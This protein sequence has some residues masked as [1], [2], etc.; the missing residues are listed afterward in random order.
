MNYK[1]LILFVVG[2]GFVFIWF[3]LLKWATKE[4]LIEDITSSNHYFYT[5]KGHFISSVWIEKEAPLINI[6]KTYFEDGVE[7]FKTF[8]LQKRESNGYEVNYYYVPDVELQ[9]Q[10]D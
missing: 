9:K 3:Y 5:H 4:N 6:S 7:Y 2:F 10:N 8:H 1:F